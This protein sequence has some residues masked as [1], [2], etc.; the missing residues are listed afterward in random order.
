MAFPVAVIQP[1]ID[2]GD[3]EQNRQTLTRATAEAASKGA[4]LIVF[5]EASISDLFRGAESLAET[6]PGPSTELIAR[7]AGAAVVVLPLLERGADGKVYSSCVLVSADGVRGVARKTHLYRDATGHDSFRDADLLAAG[8]ELSL[9]DLGDARVGILIGFDAEF[10]EAFRALALRG[11]DMICVV[12][13]GLEPD[14]KFLCA[15]ALRNRVPLLISNRLGFRKVYPAV[16]EFS[17]GALSLL[18]DRDGTFLMRSRGGSVIID[19]NGRVIAQPRQNVQ[20]NLESA[21]GVAFGAQPIA[22]FQEE[23]ALTASF[24][25]D[26]LRVARLTSPFIAERREELYGGAPT[27]TAPE[28][29]ATPTTSATPTILAEPPTSE[30]S[31]A[32]TKK[33]KSAAPKVPKE[34]KA[35]RARAKKPKTE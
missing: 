20:T 23:E 22:H 16:P 28:I 34:P 12:Q 25:V 26:D 14:Q 24:R 8:S 15:M 5:P 1:T 10:P 11:A 21:A 19:E 33:T 27:P 3:V 35:P 6:I 17:A 32:K 30:T 9:I 4:R 13:N 2:A 7:V 31:A 18:Q 29:S